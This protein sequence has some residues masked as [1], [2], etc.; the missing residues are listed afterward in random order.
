MTT[1]QSESAASVARNSGILLVGQL[2]TQGIT[3][4]LG[5]IIM[6]ALGAAEY[7]SYVSAF[8]FATVFVSLASMGLEKLLI[9]EIARHPEMASTLFCNAGLVRG[10]LAIVTYLIM[11]GAAFAPRFTSAERE[12]ALLAGLVTVLTS[13]AD[14]VRT[15]FQAF[16]RMEFDV[17][18]RWLE[19]V[20]AAI[21][22]GAILLR[23]HTA[24][25]VISALLLSNLITLGIALFAVRRFVRIVEKPSWDVG[26]ALLRMAV[27]FGITST[28]VNVITRLDP[29]FLSLL[30]P[31]TEVGWYGAAMNFIL[32]LTMLPQALSSS[33]FPRLSKDAVRDPQ[34]ARATSVFSLKWTLIAAFP[35]AG[36]LV[37][38]A[39]ILVLTLLGNTYAN[40]IL[41]LQLLAGGLVLVFVN[42][43]ASN[44]LGA[45]GRQDIVAA[46]VVGDL[47]L[48]VV[49]CLF[50]I[51]RMG[52]AGA[53][54]AIVVRDV[55][56]CA[57]M[58]WTLRRNGYTLS[59][60]PLIGAFVSGT[61]MFGVMLVLR[62]NS[63]PCRLAAA[64]VAY[65][66][67]L[68]VT[69]AVVARDWHIVRRILLEC[70]RRLAQ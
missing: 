16:E 57:A 48:T 20:I 18:S 70:Y 24:K 33:L 63:P 9:W 54:L 26:L 21:L 45:L 25:A 42:T 22:T 34:L 15:V 13:L 11:I 50:L 28:V 40:T 58:L 65:T 23:W 14:L 59:D 62:M 56:G 17:L 27:P 44:I 68:M 64:L 43:V 60:R 36:S 46:V 7:G 6:R 49:L 52:I 29:F 31:V 51:P 30:R 37:A 32:P 3:A 41:P 2:V 1:I 4:V 67:T 8:A 35:I 19:R 47:V 69:R 55:F 66:L 61:I 38:F 5:V 39:N 10:V 53:A 12:I